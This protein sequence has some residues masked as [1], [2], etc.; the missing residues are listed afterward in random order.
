LE[1][2]EIMAQL[3]DVMN[4]E[5]WLW[6][7]EEIRE[8]LP[9]MAGR[10]KLLRALNDLLG[11]RERDLDAALDRL[12][13]RVRESKLPLTVLAVGS[14]DGTAGVLQRLATILDQKK[15][16]RGL[17]TLAEE[18]NAK[19][20]AVRRALDG[21]QT[22]LVRWAGRIAEVSLSEGDG[23]DV[24]QRLPDMSERPPADLRQEVLRRA[25]EL[26][27][28]RLAAE[29]VAKW[30]RL[31]GSASPRAWSEARGLPIQW[32]LDSEAASEMLGRLN[33]PGSQSESN[34]GDLL[35]YLDAQAGVL[36]ALGSDA[37]VTAA[38]LALVPEY[39]GVLTNSDVKAMHGH[40][41][42][43]LGRDVG[44]WTREKARSAA[45]E[46]VAASYRERLYQRALDYISS[47]S[48]GEARHQLQVLAE[49]PSVGLRLLA[50]TEP[51]L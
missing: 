34:L 2:P 23:Y 49:D 1:L 50:R 8:R 47:L 13:G 27:R 31:T 25:G 7:E 48:E 26:H 43:R 45:R 4:E 38:L 35:A 28:N 44:R 29:A 12:R 37:P 19:R 51:Q 3:R 20:E 22:A 9:D 10:L 36:Q 16:G 33:D 41:Q 32:L 46:W 42:L 6:K 5:V 24:W 18:L 14:E 17:A 40:I 30:Q 39:E 11:V 21:P 15:A